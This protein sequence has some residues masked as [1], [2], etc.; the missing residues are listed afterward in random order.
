MIILKQIKH[1]LTGVWKIRDLRTQKKKTAH[2]SKLISYFLVET[3]CAPPQTNLL[4][5]LATNK[6]TYKKIKTIT[7]EREKKEKASVKRL[8]RFSVV[9]R[10]LPT[11][12]AKKW[13]GER[14]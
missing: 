11:G 12:G 1:T 2:L 10:V 6:Q 5:S 8:N 4:I 9:I 3:T 14:V 7:K 13:S